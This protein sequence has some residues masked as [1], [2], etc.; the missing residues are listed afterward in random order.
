MPIPSQLGHSKIPE[1][2]STAFIFSPCLSTAE[3][4]YSAYLFSQG[5]DMG[6]REFD[7]TRVAIEEQRA[8]KAAQV[9]KKRE[10]CI[11]FAKENP[12]VR[13]KELGAIFGLGKDTVAKILK[14]AEE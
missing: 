9:A 14:E 2:I 11:R 1:A 5:E 6:N 3:Q 13:L 4:I 12:D 7:E 8:W 10:A